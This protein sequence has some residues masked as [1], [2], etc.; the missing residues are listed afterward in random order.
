MAMRVDKIYIGV[1]RSEI[2]RKTT[3]HVFELT[4]KDNANFGAVLYR[5][6]FTTYDEAEQNGK[7]AVKGYDDTMRENKDD[8]IFIGS[9]EYTVERHTVHGG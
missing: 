3:M 9:C 7:S 4:V 2:E 8:H 6:F 5:V 1:E